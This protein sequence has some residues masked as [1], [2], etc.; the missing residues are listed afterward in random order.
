MAI[1]SEVRQAPFKKDGGLW[2]YPQLS[3][4]NLIWEDIEVWEAEMKMVGYNRGRSA[5]FFLWVDTEDNSSYPMFL[6]DMSEAVQQAVMDHGVVD[7]SW[8]IVKR[9][10]NYGL[11]LVSQYEESD[12]E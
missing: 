10:Q 11:K 7:G 8:T 1:N 9:G 12:D 2:H 5:A 4:D 6:T 3:Q